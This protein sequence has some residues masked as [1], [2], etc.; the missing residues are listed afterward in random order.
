MKKIVLI[1][2]FLA[3]LSGIAMGAGSLTTVYL[4][5]VGGVDTNSGG[6]PVFPVQTWDKAISLAANNATIYV[7][8]GSVAITSDMVINGNQYGATNVTVMPGTGYTGALFTIA[9]GATGTVSNLTLKGS[10]TAQVLLSVNNGGTLTIGGDLKVIDEGQIALDGG[11]NAINLTATPPGGMNYKLLTTY[12]SVADEGRAV[13]N[14]GSVGSPLQYFTLV[15][16]ASDTEVGYELAM[17]GST[18]RLYELPIGGIYLDPTNGNDSHSGAKSN[19]PVKTLEHAKALWNSRN[20]AVPGIITDIF[21]LSRITLTANLTL[22]GGIKL[23]R[24]AGD[25]D[26]TTLMSDYLIVYTGLELTINNATIDNGSNYGAAL[27]SQSSGTLTLNSGATIVSGNNNTIISTNSYG[28]TT[29][30]AGATITSTG[31]SGFCISNDNYSNLTVH[32]GTFTSSGSIFSK[33]YGD[34]IINDAVITHTGSGICIQNTNGTAIIN[35]GTITTSGTKA[36]SF[37]QCAFTMNDGTITS[38]RT[39]DGV[40]VSLANSSVFVMNDGTINGGLSTAINIE[41]TSASPT[42]NKGVIS[43]TNTT[44]GTIKSMNLIKINAEDVQIDGIINMASTYLT[45]HHI[46]VTSATV[47]KNY[48]IRIADEVEY[49]SLVKSNP[50]IDLG[51]YLS[52]FTLE[53][54]PGYGLIAYANKGETKRDLVLY[55]TGGV[56]VNDFNGNDS[57]TGLSPASPLKT[58]TAAAGKTSANINLNTI[59]ICDSTLTI[60]NAQSVLQATAKDTIST[61]MFRQSAYIVRIASGGSLTLGNMAVY[62]RLTNNLISGYFSV[63]DGAS[64]IL[65]SGA[66]LFL[67]VNSSNARYCINQTGGTVT[68]NA[69]S[70]ISNK[71]KTTAIDSYGFAIF[72]NGNASKTATINSGAVIERIGYGLRIMDKNGVVNI[73]D[74]AVIQYCGRYALAM[75]DGLANMNK[76][77]IRNNSTSSSY[78][79]IYLSGG[80]LNI[81]GAN[82]TNN[83]YSVLIATGPNTIVNMT[84]GQIVNNNGSDANSVGFVRLQNQATFNFSGGLIGRNIPNTTGTYPIYGDQVYITSGGKMNFNGGRIVGTGMDKNAVYVHASGTTNATAGHLKISNAAV[85][86]S[87]FIYCE[88]PFFAPI[89]LQDPLDASKK[90]NIN[91]G[92]NMAGSVLVDGSV[93]PS[94]LSN[95]VLNPDIATLALA[96]N[97]NDV[98]VSTSAIYLNGATGSDAFDG[99]TAALAVRTFA[100]ARERLYA[101]NGNYIIVV[102]SANLNNAGEISDWDL[103]LKPDAVVLRGLGYSG[104]L[105]TVP[106]GKRLTLSDITLDGNKENVFNASVQS[107]VNGVSSIITINEG[108]KI[109]N[110]DSNGVSLSYSKLYING[111]VISDNNSYGLYANNSTRTDSIVMT[112]GSITQNSSGGICTS[113]SCRYISITGGEISKNGGYGI[114]NNS[115]SN[116]FSLLKISGTAKINENNSQGVFFNNLDSLIIDGGQINNNGTRGLQSSNCRNVMITGGEIKN[117]GTYG[118]TLSA[119]SVN[120]GNSFYLSDTE[121]SGNGT[122]GM[123]INYYETCSITGSTIINNGNY[124]ISGSNGEN[125]S[126]SG[127]AVNNNRGYGVNITDFSGTLVKSVIIKNNNGNGISVANNIAGSSGTTFME[128]ADIELNNGF[129]ISLSGNNSFNLSKNIRII[130]N[131]SSGLYCKTNLPSEISGDLLI[132]G[133]YGASGGGINVSSGTINITGDVTLEADTCLSSGGGINIASAG[134]VNISGEMKI[135]KCVNVSM[136]TISTH[137]GSAISVDGILNMT[138]GRISGCT[139]TTNG[140]VLVSGNRSNVSLTGVKIYD[141]KTRHGSAIYIGTGGQITLDSDTIYNNATTDPISYTNPVTGDIH[142]AGAVAGRLY[143]RDG[144]EIDGAL[145]LNSTNDTVFIDE[146]LLSSPVGAFK[147]L[148]RSSG[149]A[150]STTLVTQ[151]GTIVVSPNGTT[152][153]D[154]SQFLSRFTIV[155]QNIGRGLDKGGTDEKH[156]IIVNQFFIDGTKPANGNGANPLTAFNR[157]AQLTSAILGTPYTTVWVSGPVTTTGNDVLP[158]ITKNNVNIRRYTGFSVAAQKFTPYDSVMFTIDEGASLTIPGGNITANN[159]T[160]S[161][162]GG[163]TLTDASIFKNNG[164]LTLGGYTT[165]FFNPTNGNGSAIYQNG[166]FNISGNV[167]FNMYS[168][169]TV[170]LAEDKVINITGPFNSTSTIGV[171]VETSPVNTHIP[172][173]IIAT[174]TTSNVP[175]GMED[176][177]VNEIVTSPLPIGRR[178]TGAT[179]DLMFYIADRNVG[180]RPPV[181]ASLQD[182][183]DAAVSADNDE[184]RLY[185]NTHEHVIADKTLRYRSNGHTVSGSFTLDS[186][187]NVRL[188]D[189]L[190]A[191]TFYIRATTFAKKAQLDRDIYDVLLT[192]A[193]YLDLRLPEKPKVGDWYPVNLPFNSEVSDISDASDST[194]TSLVMLTNYAIAEFCGQRRANFGIGNK[195]TDPNNDWQ[196]FTGSEMN[197]GTGY[198]VTSKGIRSLRFKA[199]DLNL[200]SIETAPVVY[201]TGAAGAAHF[202]FNYVSQPIG[203]NGV[204][205]NGI[206]SGIIQTS[207]SLSSDRIGAASYVAKTVNPS[208]VIAPYTNYFYQANNNETVSY[209]KSNLAAIVRSC[210]HSSKSEAPSYY[211]LRLHDGN[212]EHYDALFVAASE[213]ASKKKYEIGRDVMKMGTVGGNA[214]QLWSSGFDV[215]LCANEVLLENGRADIPMLINSPEKGKEYKLNLKNVVSWNEQLWLCRDGKLVQNLSQHPEYTIEGIGATTDEYSLRI[216][217]GTTGNGAVEEGGIYVYTENKAIVIAGIHPEDEYTIYEASGRLFAKGIAN[218]NIEKINARTGFYVILVNGN[219]YKAVVK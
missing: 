88:S 76:A 30:N 81:N 144:C 185:G 219:P 92:D 206:V 43:S 40:L 93:V 190:H 99:S 114:N 214:M 162:E 140:T 108:T 182:A 34:L 27:F 131:K 107:I 137:G 102:G 58:L 103:N 96:Q 200:F 170:Y 187:S 10:G 25:A 109:R 105:V 216:M 73:N 9:G 49:T 194:A 53:P 142:I 47:T 164:T 50:A 71:P 165:L 15:A 207:E 22:D 89:S 23:T 28:T 210:K 158:V 13:V 141:N 123:N 8:W 24:F 39:T 111:G 168:S 128:D 152:V 115:N 192:K 132:K 116:L 173:R 204:I 17:D 94:V 212:P 179:A 38:T 159:I 199:S 167:E 129:G 98:I 148:A 101:T 174:G 134:I 69:G 191:D 26:R 193:A 202:G 184:V 178:V 166:V 145:F 12:S 153:S 209:T 37:S 64:L 197:E 78:Q 79:A 203:I 86:D 150:N 3:C 85:L 84:D 125:F 91:L 213:Y 72:Q 217:T 119:G 77:I 60:N 198:M 51:I 1:I 65:D 48:T 135:D 175:E 155:N 52:N 82:I 57:N 172:G 215:S 90:Y 80:T 186:T 61:F 16:P 171:T 133:N 110:N 55:N 121:I 62:Y 33:N 205:A 45:N 14:A 46:S 138:G 195:P 147:L 201:Y 117:N 100:R 160:I 20:A 19:R 74:N 97:G 196:Y 181:Y 29:V 5:P 120:S 218:S 139:G 163:S 36:L 127:S 208:L 87:G 122:Y 106:L 70:L 211:E 67:N 59:Y 75:S 156:I 31:T 41:N 104:N 188:L 11:A 44:A 177:F 180:A 157:I 126:I 56:Y 189:N 42:L 35:G 83:S 7:T 32:G 176:R 2:A 124:G 113:N 161:G 130:E 143:L 112:S 154:A 95:F 146:A 169:N 4:N 68:M 136:S 21:V 118:L 66:S 6:D 18:I 183:F 63:E 149:P 54:K 151:P